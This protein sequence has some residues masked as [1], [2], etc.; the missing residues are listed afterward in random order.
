MWDLKVNRD[1]ERSTMAIR[2]HEM[3]VQHPAADDPQVSES[4]YNAIAEAINDLTEQAG[5]EE[6]NFN[7]MT[8]VNQIGDH[9]LDAEAA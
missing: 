4:Q 9:I 6:I 7:P 8:G 1:T 2:T 3:I 5:Q